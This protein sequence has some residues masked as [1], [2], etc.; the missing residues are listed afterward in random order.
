MCDRVG[1]RLE[2]D[3]SSARRWECACRF[4]SCF[5]HYLKTK[6][7]QEI[8]TIRQPV[9]RNIRH[10]HKED[11]ITGN[12]NLLA[13]KELQYATLS[14]ERLKKLRSALKYVRGV[15]TSPK[16]HAMRGELYELIS[17]SIENMRSP[18]WSRTKKI[19]GLKKWDELHEVFNQL[20][21]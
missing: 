19:I 11:G 10:L 13:V 21:G 12:R 3:R 20:V 14:K 1:H 2:V 4:E 9:S 15:K 6:Q 5:S 17:L 18:E 8:P 16:I 7:M